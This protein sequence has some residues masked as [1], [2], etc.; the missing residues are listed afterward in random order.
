MSK[1][2]T[3]AG[4]SI[5]RKD[6]EGFYVTTMWPVNVENDRQWTLDSPYYKTAELAIKRAKE[7]CKKLGVKSTLLLS[8]E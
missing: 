3:K 8:E 4:K 6:E 7:T 2:T 5:L 1:K